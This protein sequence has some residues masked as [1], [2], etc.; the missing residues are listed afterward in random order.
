[1]RPILSDNCFACHGPDEQARQ[2]KLRLDTKE[3]MFADRGGYQVIVAGRVAPE[4]T[5]P[6]REFD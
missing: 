4:Q 5:A 6:V 2:A 3:G 1:M